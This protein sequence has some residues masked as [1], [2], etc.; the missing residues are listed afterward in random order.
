M[1]VA[2]IGQLDNTPDAAAAADARICITM[3][4]KYGQRAHTRRHRDKR[5]L[6]LP[7][8]MVLSQSG[9][10]NI[11]K[12]HIRWNPGVVHRG[13]AY[14]FLDREGSSCCNIAKEEEDQNEFVVHHGSRF[15]RLGARLPPNRIPLTV[16]PALSRRTR[17]ILFASVAVG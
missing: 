4:Q 3:A 15:M 8:S 14:T 6:V 13:Q 12:R 11:R 9:F 7:G 17:A 2:K 16:A 1:N 5:G 10:K